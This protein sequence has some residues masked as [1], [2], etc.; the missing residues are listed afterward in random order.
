[1][2]ELRGAGTPNEPGGGEAVGISLWLVP[3]QDD[4]SRRL[5][6]W[7]N[8][9]ARGFG[10]PTFRPHLTL[11]GGLE[12]PEGEIV[13]QSTALA[14]ALPHLELRL[15]GIEGSE[16]HFRCVFATVEP[17]PELVQA[18]GRALE[19]FGRHREPAFTPHISL[20][21]G[22]LAA[23]TKSAMLRALGE[24]LVGSLMSRELQVMRTQGPADRWQPLATL[25]LGVR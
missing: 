4:A 2:T 19:L 3:Q 23:E 22:R 7:I 17:G 8:S 20:M 13:R 15:R 12:G 21:Y 18:R 24:S 5:G 6:D 1:M 16:E 10:T 14:Q 11:L 25:A 9:L